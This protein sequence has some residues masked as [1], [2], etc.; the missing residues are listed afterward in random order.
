MKPFIQQKFQKALVLTKAL[1]NVA[2]FYALS[3]KDLKEIIGIS[4]ASVS[5]L[6]QGQKVIDPETKE[7]ELALLLV[8][9]YRSLNALV[10]NHHEKA[11]IWL[12]S[13]NQYFQ[14]KPIETMKTISGLLSVTHY[15]DGMRGKL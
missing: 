14:Q 15:L 4:E 6:H 1:Q 2:K 8:R 7:G 9:I 10:G 3:G 12:N 11:K 5:R 13:P